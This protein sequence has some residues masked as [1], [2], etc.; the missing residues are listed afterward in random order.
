M[1]VLDVVLWVAGAL[2]VGVGGWAAYRWRRAAFVV[3][4]A[5]PVACFA[6]AHALV[7]GLAP[8][9]VLLLTLLLAWLTGLWLAR[10]PGSASPE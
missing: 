2:T 7:S 4:G 6:S 5:I 1:T 3:A 9:P 8:I 10:R